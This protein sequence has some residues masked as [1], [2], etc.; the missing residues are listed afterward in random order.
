M[1][2][3]IVG[4]IDSAIK[5]DA[6]A[7]TE[8]WT[9]NF[10]KQMIERGYDITL[11]ANSESK[12]P[13]KLIETT[14]YRDLIDKKTK[15][16]IKSR[17]ALLS[18]DEMVELVKRQDE[19]DLIHLSV[20]SLSY[21]LPL[22]RLIKKPLVA[23]IHGSGLSYNDAKIVIEKYPNVNFVFIS[24]S[25]AKTWPLPKKY[26]IIYNGIDTDSFPLSVAPRKY[27]F[28][29]SRISKEKGVE[30]VIKFS[31]KSGQKVVIA[32]PIRD[33]DYFNKE[34]KPYLCRNI[35]YVGELGLREKVKYY[36]GAIAFLF[37]IKWP[38]PFGLVV[39]EAMACGTPVIAY[40]LGAM[41]EI[42]EHGKTGYL[43]EPNNIKEMIK[44][45]KLCSK[46]QP[47]N[48]RNRVKKI[49]SIEHMVDQYI[50]LYEQ[51][52]KKHHQNK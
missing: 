44:F 27:Y 15:Q 3:A 52:I 32:G 31:Q 37:P 10:V 21:I 50:G 2:I 17:F 36:Q 16:I 40:D 9:Y 6:I 13:G 18:I 43:V 35:Q 33:V 25:F 41:D 5:K 46:I 23:T 39:I 28:W 24:K 7:G 12:T 20:F 47:S 26:K 1:K 14:D 8:I 49:F 42:I 4:A 48:C 11:F 51:L 30:D 34:V 45:S 29:M 38:E 22:S 19:F